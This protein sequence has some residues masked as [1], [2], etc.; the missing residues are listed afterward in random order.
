ML[1]AG[2]VSHFMGMNY[3]IH[4]GIRLIFFMKNNIK[5]LVCACIPQTWRVKASVQEWRKNEKKDISNPRLTESLR[6]LEKERFKEMDS[7]YEESKKHEFSSDFEKKMDD[8]IQGYHNK[9]RM[10]GN[11]PYHLYGRWKQ[12]AALLACIAAAVFMA[13]GNIDA[14]QVPKIGIVTR[15]FNQYAGIYSSTGEEPDTNKLVTGGEIK[16]PSR[17]LGGY[18]VD[19]REQAEWF[20]QIIY[21]SRKGEIL[22]YIQYFDCA[23]T[24]LDMDKRKY[25]K[26]I[27]GSR[28]Y[29]YSQ[30]EDF[31]NLIWFD[32]EYQYRLT[33]AETLA[34]MIALAESIYMI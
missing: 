4:S 9:Q 12:N 26:L 33:G 30:E 10:C 7:G 28:V 34:A 11:K 1:S 21:H 20:Y 3:Q 19:S 18:E 29:Y 32:E 6:L 24:S 22:H 17:L 25:D 15:V 5:C 23:C 13:G 14:V 27:I 2:G 31:I 16:E 8:L